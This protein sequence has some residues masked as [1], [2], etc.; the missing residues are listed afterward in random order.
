MK[1]YR[2][3]RFKVLI[4]IVLIGIVLFSLW[5]IN[6]YQ[7]EKMFE[8][9]MAE[10]FDESLIA[11]YPLIIKHAS[12]LQNRV[13]Q[14]EVNAKE[15]SMRSSNINEFQEMFVFLNRKYNNSNN[16][17]WEREYTL[18]NVSIPGNRVHNGTKLRKKASQA[19]DRIEWS[20]YALRKWEELDP[21]S[22]INLCHKIQVELSIAIR[23]LDDYR[24]PY[25]DINA[26]RNIG[27]ENSY[28]LHQKYYSRKN[29]PFT[30]L[31]KNNN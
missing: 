2:T 5:K 27:P 25:Q 20:N 15:A 21:D 6:N 3:L 18:F 22:F 13:K 16:D 17:Y 9:G 7:N 31:N 11:S 26:W 10:I 29:W 4:I 1:F 8:E 23:D 14:F 24:K 19:I 28:E 30:F 12:I